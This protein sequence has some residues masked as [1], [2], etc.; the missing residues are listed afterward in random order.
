MKKSLNSVSAFSI[1]IFSSFLLFGCSSHTQVALGIAEGK[2]QPCPNTP[3]C[4]YSE[5]ESDTD[6]DNYIAALNIWDYTKGDAM[7]VMAQ[8]IP[9]HGGKITTQN[10]H[11][12]AATF[13]SLIFRFVD[14]FEVRLDTEQQLIHFRSASRVGHSDFGVNRKRVNAVKQTF[15]Q[16]QPQ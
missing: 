2:L 16:R 6:A 11:Y 7:S 13:T 1:L 8:I 4:V 12:I 15:L 3:N 10:D 14:D 9:E 5:S